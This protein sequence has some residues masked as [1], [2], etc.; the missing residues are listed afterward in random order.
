MQTLGIVE[1]IIGLVGLIGVITLIVLSRMQHRQS[2]LWYHWLQYISNLLRSVL[3]W[4]LIVIG[5]IVAPMPIPF[6]IPMIIVGVAVLGPRSR[7]LRL[8]FYTAR[9]RLRELARNNPPLLGSAAMWLLSI[10]RNL[11]Q[12]YRNRTWKRLRAYEQE[13]QQGGTEN[14]SPI[15]SEQQRDKKHVG[16]ADAHHDF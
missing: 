15:L 10:E 4:S 5:M 2:A 11:M 8:M 16:V 14:S 9:R 3:G 1:V 6:G 12:S 7:R 13:R